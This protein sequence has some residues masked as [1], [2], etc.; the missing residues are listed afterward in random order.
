M[1]TRELEYVIAIAKAKSF[2][3]AAI[4]LQI[5]QSALSQ[6]VSRIER[7]LGIPLFLRSTQKVELTPAGELFIRRGRPIL[8]SLNNL[9]EEM[10][11]L[12]FG[13]A[14]SLSIGTSQFYGKYLLVPLLEALQT[15]FPDCRIHI[16]EGNSNNLENQL[17]MEKLDLAL[18]PEPI[19]HNEIHFL[20]IYEEISYFAIPTNNRKAMAIAEK[21]WNGTELDLNAFRDLPFI[22]LHK[23]LKYHDAARHFCQIHHFQPHSVYESDNLDT[24]YSLINSNYGV[25]FLPNTLLP[26]LDAKRNLVR[27]FPVSTERPQR[28]IGLAY[29]ESRFKEKQMTEIAKTLASKMD[30]RLHDNLP[31]PIG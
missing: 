29:L 3:K 19:M 7:R 8:K 16:T 17:M 4:Q 25:G 14:K 5:S 11:G 13:K 1:D 23:G 21:A 31:V 12:R 22:L 24:V 15:Q 10:E 26:T 18:F 2:S 30:H 20:P 9:K 28:H 6:Y 27:F